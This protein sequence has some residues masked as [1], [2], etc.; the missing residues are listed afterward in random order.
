MSCEGAWTLLKAVNLNLKLGSNGQMARG[1]N[2]VD[3]QSQDRQDTQTAAIYFKF[4]I[5]M[6]DKNW[7]NGPLTVSGDNPLFTRGGLEAFCTS[8]ACFHRFRYFSSITLT[9]SADPIS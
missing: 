3:N 9:G 5:S 7:C 8:S 1:N 6:L 2:L 4:Q